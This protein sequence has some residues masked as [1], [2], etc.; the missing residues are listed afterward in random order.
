MRAPATRLR[1]PGVSWRR[2]AVLCALGLAAVSAPA[3]AR[4]QTGGIQVLVFDPGGKRPVPGVEVTLSSAERHVAATTV[5]T[6]AQGMAYFPVLRAGSAYAV[7]VAHAGYARQE[8]AGIRVRSG[9]VTRLPVRLAPSFTEKV[10]LTSRTDA[11]ELDRPETVTRFGGDF[12]ED[13]PVMGRFYQDVLRLAAGVQD[14]D[15]DGNPNVH[16]ARATDFRTQVGGISNQDP[17]TGE[18]MSFVNPDSIEEIEIL[19]AGAGVEYSRAQGGFASIIQRQGSNEFEGRASFLWRSDRLDPRSA[20]DSAG[21]PQAGYQWW[22][23]SVQVSGPIVKDRLWYRLSHEWIRVEEPISAFGMAAVTTRD[24]TV[25]ADQVTWQAS[26]RNK[27][28]FQFSQDPMVLGNLGVNVWTPESASVRLE[29]GGPTYT[30]HWTAPVSPSALVDSLV[31]WQEG[32]EGILPMNEGV[33]NDCVADLRDPQTGEYLYPAL[34]D[35][36]CLSLNTNRTSGSYP[37]RQRDYRQRLTV[38]SQATLFVPRLLG[39]SHQFRL[40]LVSENERY[41]RRLERAPSLEFFVVRQP[42]E[43][44]NGRVWPIEVA[45]WDATIAVPSETHSRVLGSNVGLYAEDM[46]KPLPNLTV[47]LGARLDHE[48]IR[49]V[50]FQP[51]DPAAEAAEFA[52]LLPDD[53]PYA[54]MLTA[55]QVFTAYENLDE[56]AWQMAD[57][58]GLRVDEVYARMSTIAVSSIEWW[59]KRRAENVDLANTNVAPRLSVAW[60]P[61]G[62]GR[63]KIAATAGRYYGTIYLGVAAME[64]GPATTTTAL[65][66]WRLAKEPTTWQDVRFDAGLN[67]AASVQVVDRGLGTPYQDETT[68]A[69]EREI[70]PETS[71]RLTWVRRRFRDQLQTTDINHYVYDHGTCLVQFSPDQPWIDFSKPDGKIDDCDGEVIVREGFTEEDVTILHGPDGYPDSYTYNPAW[72]AVYV[73]GNFNSAAYDGW[74]LDLIR[75]QYRGWQLHASYTYSKAIG[76]AEEWLSP[77]GD[78]RSILDAERGYLSYDQRHVVKVGAATITPWG[79]RL[80]ATGSWESGLPYSILEMGGTY[81]S[82]SPTFVDLASNAVRQRIRYP[83]GQ[84][85]DRRNRPVLELNVKVDREWALPGGRSLQA[86]IEIF[87]LMNDRRYQI[88]NH[89]FGLGRQVNGTN[90]AFLSIGRQYQ[91]GMKLAF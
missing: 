59:H 34:A 25:S 66:G 60:D 85:N 30:L 91:I 13:L 69:F 89:D 2:A 80:G 87:N 54:R 77:L 35:G 22:M 53:S 55:R 71:L 57:V 79:Y 47:T 58:L 65:T 8:I 19:T 75:R 63:T 68:L 20:T 45:W 11:V 37:I 72:G 14:A 23:P 81:D 74:V 44:E 18:W 70:L 42:W 64:I 4:A 50:G 15:R 82:V 62:D 86:S 52:R 84:R 41:F 1:M 9:Q 48:Q 16:G 32:R 36:Q 78:D 7:T 43:D 27:L 17:L 12:I 88:Y 26:P 33:V 61:G 31:S 67:P 24:Q 90:E 73:V 3:P 28:A 76:D 51:F 6:D 38:K 5:A 83:T 21:V 10:T 29:T 40:G 56:F 49:S 46:L 39:A